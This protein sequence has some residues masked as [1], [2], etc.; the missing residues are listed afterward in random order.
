[1]GDHGRMARVLV[2]ETISE[3]GL[4]RLRDAGHEVDVRLGLTPAELEVAVK[5]AA[6][7]I[8]RSETQVTAEVLEAGTDLA[9]V[10]RAGIGLD[11][12][13]VSAATR[14]GV[15]VVN[16]PQSNV[17]SAAEHAM[18]LLLSMARNVPQ[19]N[20]ALKSGKWERTR[21]EGTELHGKVLGVVGL[22]RVG[23]LVAQRASAFGMRLVAY[24]PFV[25]ADRARQM[26]VELVTLEELMGVSHFVTIHLP[27]TKETVGLLGEHM[28]A[29]ARPGL[30]IVNTARGGI[31]DEAALNAALRSGRIGGAALDVFDKEPTTVSPLFELDTV[32]VTPHLG[33]STREAQDKAGET[34]AEQ[35]QLALSGGFVPYAVNVS[36]TEASETV[37]PF[38]PLAERLG[39]LFA[40]LNDGVPAT[41]EIE[42]QGH[43][44][45]YDT[46]ILTL[47]V[48]KGLLGAGSEEPVSYVNAPQLATERGVVVRESKTSE[49][50]EYVNLISIHG[51]T[52]GLAGTLFG[53]RS[54]ARLVMVDDH[55]V[56]I[57]PSTNMVVVRNDDRPGMIG[58]VGV[59]VGRAG[60]NISDMDVGVAPSGEAALMVLSTDRPLPAEVLDDLRAQPGILEVHA[61]GSG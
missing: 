35:V 12:V 8:I 58:L 7:L 11:N 53:L 22:G 32:V 26:G 29:L 37:R 41:L 34:I 39:R 47:A 18:A 27:R 13:D 25:S 36:A 54:E 10:G 15:M 61:V 60:I 40:S 5:G 14:R 6:A 16:A 43:L 9:V 44:A 2:S 23:A 24:D 49:A 52:H 3:R 42:Y 17:L 45:D 57:P 30:R 21:W 20:A 46:R 1:M 19:A 59:T 33:A 28:L 51:D 48:L 4:S 31:L 50:K 38:L 56:D 55:A